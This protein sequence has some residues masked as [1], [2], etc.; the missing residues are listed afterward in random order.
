MILQLSK[1]FH[2]R[3]LL[4]FVHTESLLVEFYSTLLELFLLVIYL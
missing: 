3:L 2:E 4:C 1:E